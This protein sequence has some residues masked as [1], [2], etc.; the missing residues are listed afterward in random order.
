MQRL[1]EELL[2]PQVKLVEMVVA[3]TQRTALSGQTS[4]SS[5]KRYRLTAEA[6]KLI[7]G[8]W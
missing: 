2:H 4:T 1:L 6:K 7:N 8:H 3:K 5:E